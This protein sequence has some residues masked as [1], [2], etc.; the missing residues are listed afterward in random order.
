MKDNMDPSFTFWPQF[1]HLKNTDTY[2]SPTFSWSSHEIQIG[3]QSV[4]KS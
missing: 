2:T 4:L 3:E 1:P